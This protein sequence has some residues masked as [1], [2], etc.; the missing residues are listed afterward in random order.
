[1]FKLRPYQQEA[2]DKVLDHFRSKSP[3]PA[4]VVLPTGSGKSLVIAELA[5]VANGNV[6]VLAHVKELVE[7]NHQKFESYGKKAGIYSAGLHS[8]D[9][10]E[11][12][13]F[14]SIQSVAKSKNNVFKETSI[15]IIDE[16]HRI[17]LDE[18]SQYKRLITKLRKANPSLCVLGLTATPY[19]MDTGWIYEYNSRGFLCSEQPR[20]FKK[21][22]YELSLEFMI[23][24]KYLT[25]PVKIDA[26]VACYDFSNLPLSSDGRSYRL[27]DIQDSLNAQKRITPGIV[28]NIVQMAE[29]RQGVM[30]F[31]STVEH[32]KEILKLLPKG[33]SEIVIGETDLS[34]R[35]DIV[36]KFKAKKIKF[37]VNVS[38]LTTGFDAPHVDLIALL[39][40]TESVSLFQQ[41]VGRGLRLYPGKRNCLV[42]D[43]TGAEHDLFRPE[44]AMPKP[45]SD[46]VIVA[47]PCPECGFEN[48]F[49]GLLDYRGNVVEHYGRKCKGAHEDQLTLEV[50]ACGFRFRFK[51]CE[52]CGGENDIAARKCCS[53]CKPIVDPDDRLKRA[54]ELKDAHVMRPDTM[55]FAM[56]M[57]RQKRRRLE[58]IYYDLDAKS[59]KEYF[60]FDSSSQVAA[61]HHHFVRM[62][63][64]LP[65]ITIDIQSI[66]DAIAHQASFRSP[67]FI[68]ARKKKQFWNI[69]E[70]IFHTRKKRRE[71]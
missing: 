25:M 17:S 32:A 7:Q 67:M 44:I 3:Q 40:P 68:I 39:R 66:E 33:I 63:Q 28:G 23:E 65:G 10:D 57:D 37:L 12:V 8:K 42:L 1:M 41:I 36:E 9:V 16:C 22:V 20:F 26:P 30:I 13:T 15:L 38:V 4:V 49:W 24:K 45:A 2:V 11:K 19:R 35:A 62:H 54:M 51:L 52:H 46:C 50:Q 14:G 6:L 27:A 60:Y 29:D 69:S 53:C 43:Y 71:F 18:K 21:C 55:M 48:L 47:V 64:R 58:V 59:L 34:S 56:S 31:T 61:F 70:K 5:R